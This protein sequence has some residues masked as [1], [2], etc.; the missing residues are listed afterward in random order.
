[1]T[2]CDVCGHSVAEDA[3]VCP[4]C[5]HIFVRTTCKIC[6]TKLVNDYERSKGVCINCERDAVAFT[7]QPKSLTQHLINPSQPR[8][9]T[10]LLI[11]EILCYISAVLSLGALSMSPVVG[12]LGALASVGLATIFGALREIIKRIQ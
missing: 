8:Y 11:F 2:T 7:P 12:L 4:S 1:M 9:L 10:R 5:G 6:G 3:E